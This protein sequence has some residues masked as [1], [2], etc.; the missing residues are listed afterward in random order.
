[1]ATNYSLLNA[2]GIKK[3]KPLRTSR[4]KND[5]I[6]IMGPI[7]Y[8]KPNL[9]KQNR[10]VGDFTMY[11]VITYKKD[12]N[13]QWVYGDTKALINR[14]AVAKTFSEARKKAKAIYYVKDGTMAA[15]GKAVRKEYDLN[16]PN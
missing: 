11:Y 15:V 14:V 8:F 12:R 4:V 2:R 5:I 13:N 9:S 16:G 7:G 6:V 3:Y 10:R 1:M